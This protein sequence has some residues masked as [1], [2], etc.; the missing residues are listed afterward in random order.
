MHPTSGTAKVL[1][2]VPWERDYEYLE[3]MSIVMGQKFQ[4]WWDLPA[5]DS[6]KLIKEI[7]KISDRNYKKNLEM[8][9]E[10]LS[11]R[12]ILTKRLRNM[13]LGERMKCEL[14][15][16]FLHD[17]KVVFLD[18][19]TIG[20]DIVSSRS[21]RNFL[22][23]T[24]RK[25]KTTFVLTSHYIGDIEELCKRI[26][27]ISDGKK[28]YDDELEKLKLKYA[29]KKKIE[30]SL[31]N[32]EDKKKFAHLKTKSKKIAENRG[33]IEAKPEDIGEISKEVF[34]NFD[35][36]NITIKDAETEEIIRNI[37]EEES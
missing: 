16:C 32:L 9:T 34:D 30:I 33:I 35:I 1:G 19:P 22:K 18:E 28:I 13:S 4:L 2:Y 12:G 14:A 17:P 23:E 21:I 15:A 37:F 26:V 11:L 27:I 36:E 20:L 29:P 31:Q 8:M 24:N 25:K 5:I 6:L 10:I 7:Y 3:Q